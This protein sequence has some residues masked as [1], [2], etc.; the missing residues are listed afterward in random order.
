L[1]NLPGLVS[2]SSI[3]QAGLG[4]IRLELRTGTPIKTAV[5]LVDQKLGEV[6]SYPV[7]VDRP[8]IVDIDPESV[9]FIAWIG[10][11]STDPNF[12]PTKLFDFMERRLRPRFERIPGMAEVGIRG[13][14]EREVHIRVDP[15]RLAERGITYRELV[16]AI[17][18]SN[19]DYSGGRV[20]DGKN[21]IRVR[22]IGRFS[23][24][25][26]VQR[27]VVRRLGD[28]PVTL[29]E[30]ADVTESHKELNEWVRARGHRMPFMN[31]QLDSGGNL[32]DVMTE[33]KAE[34]ARLNAPGGILEQEAQRLGLNGTLELVQTYDATTYVTDALELVRSNV[35]AGGLLATL[36]LLL[37]LRS[38]RT[39]GIIAA[40]I[41]LSVLGA[42]IILEA[43]GRSFNIISLAGIAFATGMVVDN[44]IVVL[45][46]IFRH[47]EEGKT[48]RRAA[49]DGTKEVAGAVVASTLTTIVVFIPVLLIEEAAGQLFRDI[50]L[51]IMAAVSCSL[52]VSLT[53]IPAAASRLL[54]P[55][56]TK[57][58]TAASSQR[59][60]MAVLRRV[61]AR[62]FAFFDLPSH[63]GRL[64][65]FL[66]GGWIRRL[67]TVGIFAAITI[68][69]IS[70][71]V[72]PLDYLP[73]GNRNIVFG[74]LIP[75]PAY[76]T[77]KLSDLADG[78]EARMRP[79]WEAAGE[80]LGIERALR[81]DA[82]LPPDR[83]TPLP[84]SPFAPEGTVP[85]PIEHYF[86]VALEGRVF[87]GA[88]SADKER[89][90]DTRALMQYASGPDVAPDVIAFAFQMPLFRSG[91][92]SGS[93]IKIDLIGDD[94]ATVTASSAALFFDL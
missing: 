69:G 34:V 38:L 80:R 88:I 60:P 54:K 41:P 49:L 43:L 19:Q 77:Q 33:I 62:G 6:A 66:T 40:A 94:L 5:A 25:E 8:R 15:E 42:L 93:A 63:V 13:A 48:V 52:L 23:S 68:Y 58:P 45:E 65:H 21:D 7:G 4:Q 89:A 14:R 76:N 3:S 91:G 81:G 67:A 32:L 47:L 46:N 30:L 87:H 71:L 12:D 18:D 17:E 84:A 61:S 16:A 27:L 70:V 78:I 57:V 79:F 24:V 37:F 90:V 1:G 82:P 72:P 11:S 59:G 36:T 73:A 50:A 55:F 44:A 9:D 85:P 75:P 10:L 83:R 22:A 53:L 56:K 74:L 31:F 51:A 2:L 29:G 26:Q 64:V 86:L 35:L 92:T 39:I 20:P 28:G